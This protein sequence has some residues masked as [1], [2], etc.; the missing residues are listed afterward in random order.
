MYL[1]KIENVNSWIIILKN[2]SWDQKGY[3]IFK[4]LFLRFPLIIMRSKT[5]VSPNKL[6]KLA[7][8]L[9]DILS[10]KQELKG[11]FNK[12]SKKFYVDKNLEILRISN[13][14]NEKEKFKGILSNKEVHWHSDLSYI[15]SNFNGSLLYNKENG[16]LATTCF[17]NAKE[18][19]TI[20]PLEDYRKIKG[21]F[22]YHS[23]YKAFEGGFNY[24][25]NL[26]PVAKPLIVSTIRNQKAIYLSPATLKYID[27]KDIH[28]IK[29]ISF[30]NNTPK[31]QHI[32]KPYDILIY[33]NLQLL[34]KRNAF[35]GRR[36]LYRIN[37]NFNKLSKCNS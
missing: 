25:D 10:L 14:I 6:K 33:D 11:H 32:W 30:I 27:R 29:Y 20:I 2:F 36:T 19:L 31:Y 8:T 12:Q 18:I 26:K 15:D 13:N 24:A 21:A 17:C 4:N 28:P 22:G 34:H 3:N 7:L 16:H 9:G 35:S 5:E 23:L 1:N 37:F